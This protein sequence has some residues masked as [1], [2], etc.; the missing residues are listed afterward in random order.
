MNNE[1]ELLTRKLICEKCHTSFEVTKPRKNFRGKNIPR[2]CSRVCANSR[3]QTD[4]M[5]NARRNKLKGISTGP[6][7]F[8]GVEKTPRIIRKCANTK[9]ENTFRILNSSAIKY[10]KRCSP[11]FNGGYRNG[12]GRAKHGYYKG[13]YCGSTY[14]LVW[15]IYNIDHSIIFERFQG[16]LEHDGTRYIPDFLIGNTIHEIKGYCDELTVSKKCEVARKNG[17]DIVVEYK[18]DIQYMFDYV[19]SKYNTKKLYELYD[20]Y[21]P[22]YKYNCS[23]CGIEYCNEIKKKSELNFCSR[24]CAGKHIAKMKE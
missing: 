15:V 5:N 3:I 18:K 19:E 23:Y 17:Y 21:T 24:Q 20:E 1:S 16:Q 4:E 8:K 6:S 13:I 2:F 7:P 10:C 11:L 12:S 9:C 14:E 22:K